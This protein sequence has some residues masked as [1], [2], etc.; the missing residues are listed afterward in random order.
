MTERQKIKIGL[1]GFGCVGTGLYEVL[2]KTPGFKA[3]IVKIC[4]KSRDK[5]RSLPAGYF[6]YDKQDI[7][8]DGSINVVVELIDDA[9]AAW[10]IVSEA[11]RRG[12]AVVSANKKMIAEHFEELLQLQKQYD[13]P[14][15]YEA[16]C[17]ASIPIIRNLEEY[18]DNDM[19][20]QL[21]GIVNGSTNFIL[22][23]CTGQ[24]KPYNE[25]LKTAQELG[26]AESNPALDVEGYDAK[27]KLVILLAHAF[28]AVVKPE[29]VFNE[30]ITRIGEQEIKYAREKGYKIKLLAK[31]VRNG[32]NSVNAYVMPAFVPVNH[33][34]YNIDDVFNGVITETAFADKQVFVGRGAGSYPTAS[35]VLSDISALTYLYRYEFKKLQQSQTQLSNDFDLDIYL[36]WD[37]NETSSVENLFS[38]IHEQFTGKTG[39]YING[40]IKFGN[41]TPLKNLLKDNYS[42]VALN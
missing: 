29:N 3:D 33:Q 19:L 31:A 34:L 23:S 14:F 4:V 10:E 26:Y 22:T 2:S 32:E 27:Y 8:N 5:R 24:G 38:D 25:A 20:K 39:R 37:G 16:S 41:I 21:T 28:G 9:N 30:G 40:T 36:R 42:I 35:A 18:Y 15:L 11:M 17:C 13:V 12:K 6:T 7:L 1:F